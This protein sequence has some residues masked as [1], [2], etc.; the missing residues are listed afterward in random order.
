MPADGVYFVK[1][2]SMRRV[3][4]RLDVLGRRE[5]GLAGAQVDDVDALPAQPIGF[6]GDPQRRRRR[7]ARHSAAERHALR[8][9][10]SRIAQAGLLA[11]ASRSSTTGGTRPRHFAA[12]PEHFLDQPRAGVG[13]LLGRHQEHRFEI[14]IETPV[15]QR[16]LELVLEVGDRAQAADERRARPSAARSRRAA[17]RRCRPRRSAGSRNTSRIIA[18]RSSTVNSGVLSALI[19]T[20]TMTRSKMRA[21][22]L[23]DV[24][25]PV[26]ERI[27]RAG[28]HRDACA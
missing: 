23:D 2:A 19:S 7:D 25:V 20:A 10:A 3:R 18:T 12:E 28:K 17:R 24:D 21:A 22:A 8:V 16:H 11:A 1:F 5:V 9:P 4:R 13:V 14:V 15:H 27:E 26:G 6:G